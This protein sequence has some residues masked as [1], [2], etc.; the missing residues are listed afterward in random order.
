MEK[1]VI[2]GEKTLSGKVKVSGA[3]NSALKLMAASILSEGRVTIKN[4]PGID[5]VMTMIEV[6]KHL[7]AKVSFDLDQKVLQIDPTFISSYEAP[8]ELVRK[9]RASILV[10]GP[11]LAKFG[12][13]KVAIPGGCNI[14]SRQI[15]IHLKG[16]E[17]LGAESVIEHGYIYLKSAR[18]GPKP[19]GKEGRYLQG[20][21]I[22]FDF[23]SRGATENIMMAATLA[24]GKTVINNA[25]REPEIVDLAN[26]LISM[27]AKIEGGGTDCITIH[28]VKNLKG[29][30]YRVMP[31]SIEAGTFITAAS[32]C[33]EKV[34]ICDAIWSNLET[35]CLKLREIGI[36]I[37]DRSNKSIVVKA[38]SRPLKP[39][40][41]STLPYPGFPTDL[42]PIITVLLSIVPGVSIVTE[43]VFENRFMHVEELNRMG[44]NIKVDGH[45]AIIKGVEK[46]SGAPVR[47]FD[48]RAGAALV[49]AGLVAEGTT[50]VSDIYHIRRGY[51]DFEKKLQSLGACIRVE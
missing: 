29:T 21:V 12:H 23:P 17:S 37:E 40:Y 3:K 19:S 27:G 44:A 15:D 4:I 45:H 1:F 38:V 47:A 43:N 41:I 34:E 8:Y 28:G 7:G 22:N 10:A 51:E 30:V 16:F 35:F 33:G 2:V 42:Q 24:E 14:G 5:D 6:L 39:T 11:L 26:F 49:L 25:A 9:M 20:T 48:L 46:L 50:E 32:L 18:K 13:V 36:D 31:D